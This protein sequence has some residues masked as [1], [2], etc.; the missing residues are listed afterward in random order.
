MNGEIALTDE[1]H[2]LWI[3][4]ARRGVEV[5]TLDYRTRFASSPMWTKENR[6]R[7]GDFF[8]I[9]VPSLATVSTAPVALNGA[10]G[11]K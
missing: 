2:N 5:F 6:S 3:F 10:E 7:A 9:T 11:K 8:F 1:D 4:L